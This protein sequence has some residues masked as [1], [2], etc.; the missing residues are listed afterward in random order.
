L[1][2]ASVPLGVLRLELDVGVFNSALTLNR[3]IYSSNQATLYPNEEDWCWWMW[4]SF[5]TGLFPDYCNEYF[6]T[7]SVLFLTIFRY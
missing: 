3:Y 1:T 5:C 4:C 2:F 7:C 6:F